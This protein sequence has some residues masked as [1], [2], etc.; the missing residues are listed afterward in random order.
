M[1]GRLPSF[2]EQQE[3]KRQP[4]KLMQE[5]AALLERALAHERKLPDSERRSDQ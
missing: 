2:E 4:A 3:M 1:D 5:S